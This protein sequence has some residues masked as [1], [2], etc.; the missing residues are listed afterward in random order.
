MQQLRMERGLIASSGKMVLID[1]LLPKLRRE[2]HKVLIFSQV[3]SLPPQPFQGAR[4]NQGPRNFPCQLPTGLGLTCVMTLGC[5]DDPCAGP[6]GGVLRQALLPLREA[7]RTGHR[8][9][10]AHGEGDRIPPSKLDFKKSNLPSGCLHLLITSSA[11]MTPPVWP[12]LGASLS[13]V[14]ATSGSRP[15]TASTPCPSPSSSCSPQG[16]AVWAS[17]SRPPTRSS[18]STGTP[19]I[20]PHRPINTTQRHRHSGSK[21]SATFQI[22]LRCGSPIASLV[23]SVIGTRR[24]TCRPRP[25][26]TASDRPRRSRS[27]ASSRASTSSP[28][29][30]S[31]HPSAL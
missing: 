3:T 18:S 16:R 29:S 13:A 22:H 21:R 9:T 28:P 25:A 7:R 15:S 4:P 17:T 2:G 27:T 8:Y 26:A 5:A 12:D 31:N 30:P 6:A 1:K 11:I 19:P 23:D 24:T 14:Q 10:L 20:N